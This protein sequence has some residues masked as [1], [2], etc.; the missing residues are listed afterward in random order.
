MP[1]NVELP[2]GTIIEDIPDS[3]SREQAHKIILEKFPELAP[4]PGAKEY[5]K[6]IPKA[7]GR[8]AVG[9]GETAGIGLAAA[10]PE[11]YETKARKGIES[12]AKPAQEYLAPSSRE[13]VSQ[14]PA[15]LRLLLVQRF[16]FCCR[17]IWHSWCDRCCW[18][19][20]CCRR[21]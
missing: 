20:C 15:N 1:Y 12:L 16:H 14:S 3:V 2:N 21:R 19:W 8:G 5:L 6:D 13:W 11:E 4:K 18:H 7:L 10:L 9:L 17:S